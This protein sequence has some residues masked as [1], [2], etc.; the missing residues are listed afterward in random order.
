MRL[1]LTL[2]TCGLVAATILAGCAAG[3][4]TGLTTASIGET[5]TASKPTID[6]TCVTLAVQ[7]SD[8]RA[9]GTPARVANVANAEKK[10]PIVNIKR[11]SLAKLAKL[12]ALSKEFQARCSTVPM[13]AAAL[14]KSPG[15]A[16]TTKASARKAASAATADATEKTVAKRTTSVTTQSVAI[17]P[18]TTKPKPN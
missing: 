14:P 3:D 9:E 8:A 10:S 17:E 11:E 4:S 2:A 5:R 16:P 13:Q 7:I 6:P 1:K 15:T 18:T 12:D